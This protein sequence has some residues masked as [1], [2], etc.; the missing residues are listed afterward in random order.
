MANA[1]LKA[2]VVGTG[3]WSRT[4]IQAYWSNPETEL[5][6]VCGHCDRAKA[7]NIAQQY[8]ARAYLEIGAMLE[9]ERPDVVSVIAPDASHFAPYKQVLEARVPCL[10]E[11]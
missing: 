8:G 5:V 4:H 6:A 3:W 11:K 2:A 1:R 10:L 7:E 9:R